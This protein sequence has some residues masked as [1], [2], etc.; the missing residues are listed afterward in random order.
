MAVYAWK[1]SAFFALGVFGLLAA[2]SAIASRKSASLEM[3][4]Q[5]RPGLWE[6]RD[7][8]GANRQT[9][10]IQSGRGFIQLRHPTDQCRSLILE[11]TPQAITVQYTCRA[12]GYGRTRIRFERPT[13][14]QI[15]SQGIHSGLPF[16]IHAEARRLGDCTR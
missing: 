10:C 12:T 11:D 7:H 3:L 14:V 15:E 9:L 16:E 4:G 8:G 2:T 6:L 5:I 1:S 13:L